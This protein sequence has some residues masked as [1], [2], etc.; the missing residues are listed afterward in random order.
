M[1]SPFVQPDNESQNGAAYKNN[2]DN[3]AAVFRRTAASFHIQA[4]EAP[5]MTLFCLGGP[6]WNGAALQEIA[7]NSTDAL[8]A[9]VTYGRIDRLV[10]D[11]Y[12]GAV[13][14]VA[15]EESVTPEPPA[16]PGGKLPLARVALTPGQTEIVNADITDERVATGGENFPVIGAGDAAKMLVV[17]ES[18]DG[19]AFVPGAGEN[20]G[21][22]V[23]LDVLSTL[24]F[25]DITSGS[26]T[27]V[28]ASADA[29]VDGAYD[30]LK[31]NAANDL[32][33]AHFDTGHG[34]STYIWI[35]LDVKK[36]ATRNLF[37]RLANSTGGG[38]SSSAAVRFRMD[39]AVENYRLVGANGDLTHAYSVP[40]GSDTFRIF[41]RGRCHASST[42]AM[43]L[44]IM[45]SSVPHSAQ[46]YP[47]DGVSGLLI[48]NVRAGPD[49]ALPAVSGK[50]L[51]GV[52]ADVKTYVDDKLKILHLQHQLASGTAGGTATAGSWQTRA[53]NTKVTD[54]IGSALAS[55]EFT[56]PPGTYSIDAIAVGFY[57]QGIQSRLYNVTDAAAVLYGMTA[58]YAA[59]A[60]QGP[61]GVSGVFTISGQKTFRLESRVVATRNTDGYGTAANFGSPEIYVDV[62][63]RKIA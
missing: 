62:L 21:N 25:T 32:H 33:Y 45:L 8:V 22:L 54:T 1:T 57:C 58:H 42:A 59:G 12:T 61:S 47:G 36:S 60:V 10:L 26:V 56:L 39:K 30:L 13:S 53:L 37:L 48:T 7:P 11:R 50:Q 20:A 29:N 41:L 52:S 18:E 44:Q 6:L 28:N 5:D 4:Q 31:E 40:L 15:G 16:I 51:T 63:I 3:A 38:G 34:C 19:Y 24:P 46:S 2:L 27:K 9:P 14:I 55:N 43:Y 35:S 17:N 49:I 23:A